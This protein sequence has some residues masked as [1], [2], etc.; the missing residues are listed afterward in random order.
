M[1][2]YHDAIPKLAKAEIYSTTWKYLPQIWNARDKGTELV[3]LEL[4]TA[5]EASSKPRARQA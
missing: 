1:E 5:T 2:A 4:Q 3:Q